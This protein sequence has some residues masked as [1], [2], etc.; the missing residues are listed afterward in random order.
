MLAR[1]SQKEPVRVTYTCSVVVAANSSDV[2]VHARNG[3]RTRRRAERRG[4]RTPADVHRCICPGPTRGRQGSELC[5][6]NQP[7]LLLA[8]AHRHPVRIAAGLSSESSTTANTSCKTRSRC[9]AD[10]WQAPRT[11]RDTHRNIHR[12]RRG[13]PH[14]LVPA[15]G[16]VRMRSESSPSYG[17]RPLLVSLPSAIKVR[18][19]NVWSPP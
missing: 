7:R 1:S 11:G 10:R 3:A 19:I 6:P 12:F 4:D 15:A 16:V 14:L 8:R 13:Y 18:H 9:V 2:F 5:S 17:P